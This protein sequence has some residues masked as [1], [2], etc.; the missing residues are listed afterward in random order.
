MTFRCSRKL[1]VPYNTLKALEGQ[2]WLQVRWKQKYHSC[3]VKDTCFNAFFMRP[4]RGGSPSPSQSPGRGRNREE[5]LTDADG[6]V[7]GDVRRRCVDAW[8]FPAIV[9]VFGSL[10]WASPSL[11]LSDQRGTP[12]WPVCCVLP[13]G[14]QC[15]RLTGPVNSSRLP[16]W[17]FN[18]QERLSP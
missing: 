10:L 5:L 2:C 11:P 3:P 18:S 12:C 16:L 13:K 9:K 17:L 14:R 8:L 4:V 1:K 7:S 15:D 6:R